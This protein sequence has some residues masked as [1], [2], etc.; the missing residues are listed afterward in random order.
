MIALVSA[1]AAPER[2]HAALGSGIWAS[3]DG[4]VVWVQQSSVSALA[5]AV[6]PTNPDYVVAATDGGLIQSRDS[7]ITWAALADL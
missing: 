3:R 2:L 5:L 1:P 6:H 7:G 4:G